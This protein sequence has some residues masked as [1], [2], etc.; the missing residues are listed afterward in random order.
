MSAGVIH[1]VLS[2]IT[3][4]KS[5]IMSFN[6]VNPKSVQDTDGSSIDTALTPPETIPSD[7]TDDNDDPFGGVSYPSSYSFL[8]LAQPLL[9]ALSCRDILLRCLMG[10]LCWPRQATLAPRIGSA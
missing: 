7:L 4:V 10:R 6:Q 8:S 5:A 1:F 3:V 2:A 9:S